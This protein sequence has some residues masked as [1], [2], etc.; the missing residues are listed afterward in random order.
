MSDPG[1]Y[2]SKET[3]EHVKKHKDPI[4]NLKTALQEVYKISLED[5]AHQEKKVKMLLQDVLDCVENAQYPHLDSVYSHV[6]RN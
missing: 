6:Y 3:L 5:I 1:N 4:K 2:R